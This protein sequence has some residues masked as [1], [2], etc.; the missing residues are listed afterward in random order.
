MIRAVHCAERNAIPA[1]AYRTMD[2]PK[3]DVLYVCIITQDLVYS[4]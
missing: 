2:M 1:S 4:Q 3:E